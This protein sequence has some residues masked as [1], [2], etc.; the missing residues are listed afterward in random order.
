MS[1]LF[2]GASRIPGLSRGSI[3]GMTAFTYVVML[4]IPG[5]ALTNSILEEFTLL[6]SVM[7][8]GLL[9]ISAFAIANRVKNRNQALWKN[10]TYK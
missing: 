9:G 4:L 1:I 10:A 3:L 8:A 6:K 5:Y 2:L 7:L